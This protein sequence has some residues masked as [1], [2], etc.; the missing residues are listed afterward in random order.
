MGK[1]HMANNLFFI[2]GQQVQNEKQMKYEVSSSMAW[3][4]RFCCIVEDCC[5]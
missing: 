2:Y 5:K 3:Q 4:I 1:Q